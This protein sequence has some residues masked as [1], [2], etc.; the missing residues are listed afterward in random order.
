MDADRLAD[1][2][3]TNLPRN[4]RIATTALKGASLLGLAMGMIAATPA[5]AADADAPA[6]APKVEE[7]IVT[8]Q[9]HTQKL[10]DTPIAITALSGSS[11]EDRSAN[12]LSAISDS[13]PS[14]ILRPASAAFGDSITASIRGL[15]QGDFDPAMEPGVGIYIDDVYFPRLT[16]ANLDLMDVDRVEVLRGPQG[17]LT[18][19]NSEGG[20]IKFYSKVP[21]GDNSGYITATYGSR[22]RINLAGSADFKLVD[23]LYGRISGAYGDQDGYINVYDFGCRNPGQ[24]VASTTGGTNCLKYKEG[25]VGYKAVRG[26]LR[27]NPNDKLDVTIS[28]DYTK[29]QHH[30][31]AQVLLYANNQNPN[32]AAAPGVPYDSRFICGPFC[33]YDTTGQG[34]AT[35]TAGLLPFLQGAP[36][37]ATSGSELSKYTGWGVS[38]K[39]LYNLT[40]TVKL[41][42]ITSY[43]A[44][45]DMFSVDNDLSPANVG[46][47]NNDITDWSWSQELR[48]NARLSNMVNATLGGYY[49]DEKA[50]YYTLQDIR[51]VA[52]GVPGP[53]CAA[54]GGVNTPTCPVYPLQFIGNDPITTKSKG[55]Y[56]DIEIKPTDGLTINGGLRYT[57]D[58]KNYTFVRL[59]LDGVTPQ[60]FLG[61]LNGFTATPF[62]GNRLDYRFAVDYRFNPQAMVYA[63]VAS[64]YKAGGDGPRPFNPA[65]AIAFGSESVVNYEIG[66]KTDLLD[67]KLR[68]NLDVFYL[69]F[70]NAQLTLL[71]C[72]QY[73]GAGPCALPQNAGNA[74]SKGVEAEVTLRPVAGLVIDSSLSY[75]DWK[76]TCVNP[77]VVGLAQGP[78]SSD[79]SV[80]SLINQQPPGLEKW[81]WNVG[82]QYDADLGNAGSLTPRIDVSYQGSQIGNVLAATPG[83]PSA[84]YGQLDAYTL[85]NA[86]LTWR[87]R[88]RD[89]TVALAVTNVF[90]KYYYTSKFDLTGA[91]AGA[92]A[93]SPGRPREWSIAIKKT[94]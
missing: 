66:T 81:K 92:I 37:Q 38:G 7:I 49:S 85:T 55:V 45:E 56:G 86:R 68:V 52:V 39:I 94:F 12:N 31:A 40:D 26:I 27:Y 35:F 34:A 41:T 33:N 18:G 84:L 54:I 73:G 17:T 71:S 23:G 75:Q 79:Q 91:G 63:S 15:G 2:A 64:G 47:G 58:Q 44:F 30:N 8:A 88:T 51:Y 69:D 74:H 42:S 14:V 28:G 70:K 1:R 61:A 36:F 48:L 50:V 93:G 76:W 20:A 59:N 46:F 21:N 29:D 80:I 67:R 22:N 60:T 10:Q 72:P 87:S 13:A 89:L 9:F 53:V 65:Q 3:E 24:G 25:D 19:K 5:L 62:N 83:S 32:V 11:L 90:D 57:N 82:A 6:A 43:R 4:N 16:G 77:Q 78:C